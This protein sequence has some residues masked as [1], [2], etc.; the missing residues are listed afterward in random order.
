MTKK[1][2]STILKDVVAFVDVWSTSKRENYSEGFMEQLEK[3]GA[4]VSRTL[5]KNVTHVI[6][7]HGHQSTWNKAQKM[8][9]KLVSVLWVDKCRSDSQHVD[10]NLCPAVNEE[11]SSVLA[12]KRTHKC[13]QPRDIPTRT[14]E[15]DRRLKRKLDKMME[16]LTP[17]SPVVSN[18]SPLIIDE[19]HGIVYSP[20]SK[21]AATMALRLKQMRERRE[22]LSPTASQMVDSTFTHERSLKPSIG[23][24]PSTSFVHLLEEEDLP[25]SLGHTPEMEAGGVHFMSASKSDTSSVDTITPSEEK[26]H[27]RK[28]RQLSASTPL[29]EVAPKRKSSRGRVRSVFTDSKAPLPASHKG[30][31]KTA[32]KHSTGKQNSLDSY[33]S[34]ALTTGERTVL[35]DDTVNAEVGTCTEPSIYNSRLK[36]TPPKDSA[37]LEDTQTQT[38]P[39]FNETRTKANRLS[40]SDKG[41]STSPI[42]SMSMNSEIERENSALVRVS[43]APKASSLKKMRPTAASRL[44]KVQKVSLGHSP[45]RD[46]VADDVFEDYFSSAEK[47]TK[48]QALN[49]D[50]SPEKDPFSPFEMSTKPSKRKR[51]R[52][53]P[54]GA[55][56]KKRK[57]APVSAAEFL[58]GSSGL[59]SPSEGVASPSQVKSK[60]CGRRKSALKQPASSGKDRRRK[61]K[62]EP[63]GDVGS[64]AAG[65]QTADKHRP[66][67]AAEPAAPADTRHEHAPLTFPKPL[68]TSRLSAARS[69]K[70]SETL[71]EGIKYAAD[72]LSD[73]SMEMFSCQGGEKNRNV[74]IKR[75]LVMTSMPTEKQQTVLQ[76]VKSLGGFSVVDTVCE[77]TT[78]VVAGSPRRTLNILLGIARGCWILSYEW[79]MWCL[80]HRQWIPEEPYE[81]SDD[82]PAAPICRLQ[83]HLSAGEHQQDLFQGLPLMFVSPLSQ[84]PTHSL[85][86]LIRLCGGAVCRTVRQAGICIGE[87]RGRKPEGTRCLSE[88]WILDCVTHLKRFPYED[89]DLEYQYP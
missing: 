26:N 51:E 50:F 89:Y 33:F 35:A 42:L 22:N 86:E 83:Q 23:S 36:L 8:G 41:T 66:I 57:P 64:D 32:A 16:R 77:S 19:E 68:L 4:K 88:Q 65:H 74:Q 14:P 43:S 39:T 52:N 59:S 55:C 67:E 60:S 25:S 18:V 45:F 24:S 62:A 70:G 85:E 34:T 20:S 40:R 71:G 75:T 29:S 49:L 13:M 63:D 10:E 44:R 81:M 56:N 69:R 31:S 73:R 46:G 15:N 38:S 84:P 5:N 7:K 3:M 72:G 1:E 54:E 37:L 61:P 76:V 48:Q 21:T 82:F 27:H 17:S 11:G 80:E 28:T 79:I 78:H 47:S 6:F 87:Y 53:E 30:L 12:N 9:L 58:A 2:S